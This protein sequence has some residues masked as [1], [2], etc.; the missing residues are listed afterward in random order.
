MTWSATLFLIAHDVLRRHDSMGARITARGGV[1]EVH[2]RS[3]R[4][5]GEIVVVAALLGAWMSLE[6]S[7]HPLAVRP[8]AAQGV[9]RADAPT[10]VCTA[11]T[12][13]EIVHRVGGAHVTDK[14]RLTPGASA[15]PDRALRSFQRVAAY[16]GPETIVSSRPLTE[17]YCFPAD[18]ARDPESEEAPP[19][20][21]QTAVVSAEDVHDWCGDHE[22]DPHPCLALTPDHRY[23]YSGG[24]SCSMSNHGEAVSVACEDSG[25]I[26]SRRGDVVLTGNTANL[27]QEAAALTQA[28]RSLLGDANV[29]TNFHFNIVISPD[30]QAALVG[31]QAFA[32]IAQQIRQ[33]S[34]LG[35]P[36]PD[37][38]GLLRALPQQPTNVAFFEQLKKAY[39]TR[40][41]RLELL[42]QITSGARLSPQQ[43]NAFYQHFVGKSQLVDRLLVER[44]APALTQAAG[45]LNQTIAQLANADPLST[46]YEEVKAGARAVLEA[47]TS[48]GVFDPDH[49][50]PV[51]PPLYSFLTDANL[52][53]RL[54]AAERLIDFNETLRKGGTQGQVE[55]T[56]RLLGLLA[57]CMGN[58][59][60][61]QVYRVYD[62]VEAT[63]FF[64]EGG[65]PRGTRYDVHLSNDA[66]T[67]FNLDVTPTSAAAYDVTVLLNEV[68]DYH[69]QTGQISGDYQAII[70]LNARE[71]LRTADALRALYHTAEASSWFDTAKGFVGE[72]LDD[73]ADTASGIFHTVTQPL[74]TYEGLKAA[75]ANWDQTLAL[76]WQQ[77]A[78]LLHRWPDMTPD[79]KADILGRLAGQ[80]VTEL[81]SEVHQAG[82]VQEATREAVRIHLD[83]AELGLRIIERGGVALAPEA[84]AELVRRMEHFGVTAVD[85]MIELADELDDHLPCRLVGG[86]PPGFSTA[87]DEPACGVIQITGAFN[88]VVPTGVKSFVGRHLFRALARVVRYTPNKWLRWAA[89]HAGFEDYADDFIANKIAIANQLERVAD[90]LDHVSKA[91]FD[92]LFDIMSQLFPDRHRFAAAMAKVLETLAL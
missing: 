18:N 21:A 28:L 90:G 31:N 27:R 81:P 70:A 74:E 41:E 43:V 24:G 33:A 32:D 71:A 45:V 11:V 87:D 82:R 17:V 65:D 80:I 53:K 64:A 16:F 91:S 58:N 83:K 3:M 20:R 79:E 34:D 37:I 9:S 25:V 69:R 12:S 36:L 5:R 76:V 2:M 85:D 50:V 30:Q 92:I 35:Q 57:R 4:S 51:V 75:I 26:V 42:A 61:D 10:P 73:F 8:S 52:E 88:D 39:Q 86:S 1:K 72:V 78:E 47:H 13:I 22:T 55:A 68:A 23:D 38:Q 54:V 89:K 59:D 60:M 29:L 19:S 63:K 46:I 77:G 6:P 48:S 84:A 66:R 62:Q 44:S 67:M 40:Q 14:V 56:R 49:V 15:D 7:A